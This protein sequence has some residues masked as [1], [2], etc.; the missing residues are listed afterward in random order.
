IQ[1]MQ[2]VRAAQ[3]QNKTYRAVYFL[4]DK[5]FRQLSDE[6]GEVLPAASGDFAL[7]SD[8]R[9]YRFLTGYGPDLSDYSVVNVRTGEKKVLLNDHYD[10]WKVALDGSEAKTLTNGL[11]RKNRTVLHVVPQ[12]QNDDGVR[13]RGVDLTKPVLLKAVNE[14]TRDEGFYRLEP[15]V[16]EPKL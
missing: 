14:A 3:E 8:N 5:S 4:K 15:G 13:E 11:G 12:P 16:A 6:T 10:I 2:K 9:K 7:G 1:P